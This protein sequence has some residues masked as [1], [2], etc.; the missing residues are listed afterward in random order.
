M[1]SPHAPLSVV[2]V[3]DSLLLR[4]RICC[5]ARKIA[6]IDVVG[7]AGSVEEGITLFRT[8]QPD[9]VILDLQL[10][11]GSGWDVLEVI[12]R[13]RPATKVAIFTNYPLPQFKKKSVESGAEWFIDKTTEARQLEEILTE[14]ASHGGPARPAA[15]GA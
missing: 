15:T 11:G 14:L 7:E 12:K 4:K 9:V 5:R 2:I 13:E 8:L 1:T 3:D 6:G 10:P